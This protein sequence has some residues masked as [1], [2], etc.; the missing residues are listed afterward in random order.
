[1]GCQELM[2]RWYYWFW[3][4]VLQQI[5]KYSMDLH[6]QVFFGILSTCIPSTAPDF[7][8]VKWSTR[9]RLLS[10]HLDADAVG[11]ITRLLLLLQ[12]VPRSRRPT[13]LLA[14][15]PGRP[16]ASEAERLMTARVGWI[17]VHSRLPASSAHLSSSR[18]PPHRPPPPR[19]CLH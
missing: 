16:L 8:T 15:L 19:L 3:G 11:H 6:W 10:R 12:L 5:A 17:T 7:A 2:Y 14:R 1:M 9:Q 4:A 18:P 13:Y